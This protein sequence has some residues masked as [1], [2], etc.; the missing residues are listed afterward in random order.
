MRSTGFLNS[1]M[2][3]SLGLYLILNAGFMVLRLPPTGTAAIPIGEIFLIIYLMR[4]AWSGTIPAF[5]GLDVATPFLLWWLITMPRAFFDAAQSGMWALRD[6]TSAIE[7]LFVLVGFYFSRQP[8]SMHAVFRWLWAIIAIGALYAL[9]Y[10]FGD[11]LQHLSPTI[12]AAA[13][14]TTTVLFQYNTASVLLLLAS[15][16][17]LTR[18]RVDAVAYVAACFLILFAVAVFQARTAY[19]QVI[20]L[21]LMLALYNRPAFGRLGAAIL[22]GMVSLAVLGSL[23]GIELT[24]R[25]GEKISFDFLIRHFTSITGEPAPG[26]EG[27]AGGIDLRLGWWAT[28]W[29]KLTADPFSLLFGLGYGTPLTDFVA[30]QNAIV[31]EPHN[32]LVSVVARLGLVGGVVFLWLQYAVLREWQRAFVLSKRLGLRIQQRQLLIILAYFVLIWCTA[33][34]EDALEKPYNAIPYYFLLGVAIGYRR[35]LARL[36]ALAQGL[37]HARGRG[38]VPQLSVDPGGTLVGGGRSDLYVAPRTSQ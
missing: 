36:V 9:T 3:L 15:L 24:G 22:I 38:H 19:L 6:A 12:E 5:F 10:P 17:L 23:G 28:I 1:L 31:R 4:V 2:L 13:G 25:L 18:P 33:V 34:G 16:A 11:L 8:A 14:Y 37:P 20:A 7:S 21:F 30:T 29:R 26:V 35:H 32:S 27:A